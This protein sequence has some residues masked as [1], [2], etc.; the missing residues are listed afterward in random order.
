[1]CRRLTAIFFVLAAV[2]GS[3]MIG[4][5]P[6]SAAVEPDCNF[7]IEDNS[8]I[9]IVCKAAPDNKPVAAIRWT[10]DGR[11]TASY[12]DRSEIYFYCIRGQVYTI[13]R[14]VYYQDNTSTA[15]AVLA[16]CPQYVRNVFAGCSSGGSRLQCS[17]TWEGG[18]GA[19]N[20]RW[21]INGTLRS[22]FNDSFWLDISCRAPSVMSIQVTVYDVT[23]SSGVSSGYCG[24]HDGPLD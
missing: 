18:A 20:I 14:D 10:I 5:A 17:V 24:C 12:D 23:G 22:F 3:S 8:L 11:P 9:K 13:R 6:A 19:I 2:V 4:A 16:L 1:M 21:V 15:G 7:A